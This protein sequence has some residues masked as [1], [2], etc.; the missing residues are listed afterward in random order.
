MTHFIEKQ[1]LLPHA[2]LSL[3]YSAVSPPSP[4]GIALIVHGLSE[5]KGRY[6]FL[7]E[8]L[9]SSGLAAYAYDQRGFGES[10]GER[11]DIMQYTDLVSDLHFVL[12]TI[13]REYPGLK[14]V[15]I[16]HS[17]GGVVC[18]TFCIDSPLTVDSLVLSAPAYDPIGL[19]LFLRLLCRLLYFIA[20][21]KQI[22]YPNNAARLSHDITVERDFKKDPLIQSRGTPRFYV[23]FMRMNAL[24]RRNAHRINMP[25]LI[26]QGGGDRTVNPEGARALFRKIEHPQKKLLWYPTYYHEVF[27]EIGKEKVI[28]SMLD[29]LETTL[30]LK[31]DDKAV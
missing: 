12:S 28:A 19:S 11:T 20:P 25:T 5:H 4:K 14:T 8:S 7:Q 9:A 17:L 23:E 2:G 10:S 3:A 18:A 30:H 26:L 21:A 15:L 31:L 29:W 24:L 1:G 16:G 22:R 6:R 13:Q 27:N